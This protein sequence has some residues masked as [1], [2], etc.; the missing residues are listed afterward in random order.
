[1]NQIIFMTLNWNSDRIL[2]RLCIFKKTKVCVCVFIWVRVNS[3]HIKPLAWRHLTTPSTPWL[4]SQAGGSRR[5]NRAC[6]CCVVSSC[7][8]RS[9]CGCTCEE[10]EEARR[11]GH[12]AHIV[13]LPLLDNNNNRRRDVVSF[14][15]E[16]KVRDGGLKKGKRG[17]KIKGN[18]EGEKKELWRMRARIKTI[19]GL[20]LRGE[21]V[22]SLHQRKPCWPPDRSASCVCGGRLGVVPPAAATQT[23]SGF[24]SVASSQRR[25]Q[26]HFHFNGDHSADSGFVSYQNQ[27]RLS[28]LWAHQRSQ[29]LV[30]LS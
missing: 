2:I 13:Q 20:W 24:L 1:M 4:S 16:E 27:L 10:E 25:V 21:A 19:N 12:T 29:L 18:S 17:R 5:N 9:G 7:G 30:L 15:G 23:Q 26:A 14:C 3:S 28:S 22:S 6:G 11:V 8:Q